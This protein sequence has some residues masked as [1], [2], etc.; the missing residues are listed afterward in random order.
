M[1]II[2]ESG[3]YAL[4]FSS[5]LPKAKEFKHWVTH[6]VLPSPYRLSNN[7]CSSSLYAAIF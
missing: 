4:V 5:K 1:T 7:F 2:N 3:M 6:E